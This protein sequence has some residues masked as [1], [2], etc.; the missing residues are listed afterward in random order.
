M[1]ARY[2]HF[3]TCSCGQTRENGRRCLQCGEWTIYPCRLERTVRV[4]EGSAHKCDSRCT[5]AVGPNCECSCNGK[6]HGSA[7]G[8]AI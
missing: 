7:A 2:V 4:I 8:I 1:N 6:N 5:N 3:V